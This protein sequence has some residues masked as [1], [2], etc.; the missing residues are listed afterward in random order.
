M[1]EEGTNE[2]KSQKKKT[3]LDKKKRMKEQG[4]KFLDG[5]KD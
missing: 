4:N 5:F 2:L 3:I 1:E